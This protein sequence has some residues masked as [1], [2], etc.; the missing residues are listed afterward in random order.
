M[1]AERLPACSFALCTRTAAD[2]C[3]MNT[4]AVA[5]L[6][7]LPAFTTARCRLTPSLTALIAIV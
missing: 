2:V 4:L 3:G 6:Y 7:M 5:L 1:I